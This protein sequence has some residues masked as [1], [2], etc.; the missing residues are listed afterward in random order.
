MPATRDTDTRYREN[1][2]HDPACAAGQIFF[3]GTLVG[4]NAAGQAGNFNATFPRCIG[5]MYLRP[6]DVQG[7]NSTPEATALGDRIQVRRGCHRFRQDGS[8]TAANIG[9]VARGM[10]DDVLGLTGGIAPVCIIEAVDLDGFVW[11]NFGQAR[12]SAAG[13]G[14]I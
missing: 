1:F 3:K 11:G 8:I 2:D 12:A 5:V 6:R 7:V 10:D 13:N 9:Q 14:I 4:I